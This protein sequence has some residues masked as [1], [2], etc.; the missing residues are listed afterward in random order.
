[1]IDVLTGASMIEDTIALRQQLSQQLFRKGQFHLRKWR[2][3]NDRVLADLSKDN[4]TDNLLKIEK[5]GSLKTLGLHWDARSDTLQYSVTI[6]ETSKI[7]KRIVLSKIAQIF[8]P[9][10]LLGP[11]ITNAKCMMQ[12]LWQSKSGW[13]EPLTLE[14]QDTWRRYYDSLSKINEI[15]IPRNVN[16]EN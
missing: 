6:E 1:M 2:S 15:R 5:K 9:L 12:L 11:V 16:Q 10:G 13:D 4:E 14:L 7:T 8:D 3:N